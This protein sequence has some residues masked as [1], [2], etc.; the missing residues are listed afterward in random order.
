MMGNDA[1]IQHKLSTKQSKSLFRQLITG[2]SILN[3]LCIA[4]SFLTLLMYSRT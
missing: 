3:R 2:L 4:F 1:T